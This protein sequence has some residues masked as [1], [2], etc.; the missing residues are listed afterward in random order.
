MKYLKYIYYL[1]IHKWYVALACFKYGL[2]WIGLTHDISKFLPSEF[3]PYMNH[4]YGNGFDINVGRKVDGY[5][6]PVT[7]GDKA[8]DFAWLL[9]QKRNKHHWQFWVLPEDVEGT[10]ILEMPYP[11]NIEM[12][13][14]W[15]G[16]GKVQKTKGVNH[17]YDK[18]KHKLQLHPNTRAFVEN[19][20][21]EVI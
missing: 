15:L 19:L 8:F 18:H 16:A 10:N 21:K 5:Y 9:H 17:W 11:Y 4:F 14:D 7:T 6:K 20:I 13:C 12:V 3:F 2:V 1:L